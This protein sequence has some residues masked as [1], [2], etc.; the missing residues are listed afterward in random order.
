MPVRWLKKHTKK[1]VDSE[2][3]PHAVALGTAVGMFFGFTPLFGLKTLLALGVTWMARGSKVAALVGVAL[4]DVALP[5]MPVLLRWE[6]DIGYWLMSHPHVFP[7]RM[8]SHH[9]R[10][11][12]W[13][14][15]STFLTVGRPLLV[16]SVIVSTPI[17]L[18]TYGSVQWILRRRAAMKKAEAISAQHPIP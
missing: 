12:E 7:E 3:G 4:H 5:F 18:V 10:P 17:A 1:L 11:A 16:G 2:D 15:W 14:N 6:Y 9:L 13:F 8:H